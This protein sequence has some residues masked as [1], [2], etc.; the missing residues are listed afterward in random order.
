MCVSDD[1]LCDGNNDCGDRSD[2]ANCGETKM[3]YVTY[4]K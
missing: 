2:E 3:Y 4:V 1:L